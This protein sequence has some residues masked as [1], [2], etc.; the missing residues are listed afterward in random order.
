MKINLVQDYTLRD[1]YYKLHSI[2]KVS[3]KMATKLCVHRI[4]YY[5]SFIIFLFSTYIYNSE[6]EIKK[7]EGPVLYKLNTHK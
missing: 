7:R 6:I 4:T 5:Y 2:A 1:Y 3:T